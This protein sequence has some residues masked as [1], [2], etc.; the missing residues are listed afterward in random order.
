MKRSYLCFLFC[1][2]IALAG[3]PAF[4]QFLP[5]GGTNTPDPTLP[6]SPSPPAKYLTPDDVH[7]TYTG[8]ISKS[9][10]RQFSTFRLRISHPITKADQRQAVSTRPTT[11]A[12]NWTGTAHAR[13]RA[14]VQ[15]LRRFR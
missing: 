3:S 12:P 14:V 2:V 11:S 7:A 8:R 5:G 1:G 13:V 4:A 6:P 10:C 9:S 15:F